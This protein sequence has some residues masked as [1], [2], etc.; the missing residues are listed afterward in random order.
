MKGVF[1]KRTSQPRYNRIWDASLV[2]DYLTTLNP[3]EKLSLKDLTLKLLMLLL[4]TGK[5]GQ[6]IHLLNVTTMQLDEK[7][8]S[9]Q[10]NSHTKT[11][12]PGQPTEV[13]NVREFE[14]DRG[15]CPVH[16]LREYIK[17]TETIRGNQEQLF[18]SFVKPH[19]S[20]SRDTISR[21]TKTVLQNSGIYTT[22][23]TSHSTRA[24]SAS[25]AKRRDVPIDII[26]SHVGWSTTSFIMMPNQTIVFKYVTLCSVVSLI[27]HLLVEYKH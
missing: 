14:H 23:F 16:T 3:V 6:S 26:L 18:I 13:I 2:L 8:C 5:R 22:M 19:K 11:S 21:W 27:Q 12:K 9:F 24:A 17:R 20:V 7:S 15:V 25:K 10:L 4:A 1:E